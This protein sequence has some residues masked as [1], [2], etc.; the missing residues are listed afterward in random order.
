[1]YTTTEVAK[2]FSVDPKTVKRWVYLGKLKS[3]KTLG[4]HYRFN[5]AYVDQLCKE[6]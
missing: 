1:M 3:S 5:K 4:G 6:L 2:L